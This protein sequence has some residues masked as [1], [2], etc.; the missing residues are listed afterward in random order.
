MCDKC[1]RRERRDLERGAATLLRTQN[2]QSKQLVRHYSGL[3]LAVATIDVSDQTDSDSGG[4]SG[5]VEWVSSRVE[6]LLDSVKSFIAG[7]RT[8]HAEKLPTTA[9]RFRAYHQITEHLLALGASKEMIEEIQAR[10]HTRLC[11]L[12]LPG[13]PNDDLLNG[14]F[15]ETA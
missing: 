3:M 2:R 6:P 5:L 14:M 7:Q 12:K 15:G 13:H 9:Q 4:S 10:I 11:E 1:Y 8:V